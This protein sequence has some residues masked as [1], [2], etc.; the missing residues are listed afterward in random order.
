MSVE[1]KKK[2]Q[3]VDIITALYRRSELNVMVH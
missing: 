2:K 1:L 3:A